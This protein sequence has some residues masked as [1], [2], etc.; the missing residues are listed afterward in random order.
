ME[1]NE[2]RWKKKAIL[3]LSSQAVTLFGSSLVQFAM[4]WFVTLKTSSGTWVSALSVC[5]FLPQF[6]ISFVAGVWADRYPRKRL[7][8]LADGVIAVTT[9][10][11]A[12]SIPHLENDTVL[13][14]AILV[15]SAIRSL[16]AGIQLPAVNAVIPQLVP[17]SQL[18]RFNGLNATVQSVVQFAAPAAAGAILT[19]GTL[20]Q[21]LFIDVATA[22][23]GIGFLA[24][25]AIPKTA[26]QQDAPASM[27]EDLRIGVRY[28]FSTGFLKKLLLMYGGFIF[29]CVPAGFLATLFVSREY[30]D[31]Y[32]YLTVVEVVG[33]I[34]MAAGGLLIS[35]WGGFPNR[36]KTLIAGMSFFGA[37]AV[38]MG[39]VDSFIVYLVCMLIYGVTLTM[40]QTATTTLL[41][42]KAEPSMQGRVFG[43]LSTMY[44][45]ALP[46]GMAVFG[47]LAD[48]VSL[49]LLMI[50]S[51]AILLLL[52]LLLRLDRPFFLAGGAPATASTEK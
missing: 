2:F 6:L 1:Q 33:F 10:I 48:V 34:G 13:L 51:G 14:S 15:T 32:L 11:L 47:P 7:I 18:M 12:L 23:V 49:R 38:G 25:I 22:I 26:A 20:P 39:V 44:S 52:A 5:A 28:V 16:G 35:I 42:E 30:G 46:L 37:L 41:Q 31:S 17:D 19:L 21:T 50:G 45:G 4:V 3:F 36:V 8:I 29:L 43:F 9:L 24:A 40:V 27:L